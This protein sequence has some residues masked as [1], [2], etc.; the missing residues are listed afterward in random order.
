MDGV[1]MICPNCETEVSQV[2]D[3]RPSGNTIRRR[4]KCSACS[5]RF[6]T[7]EYVIGDPDFSAMTEVEDILAKIQK[8][9]LVALLKT[10]DI[11]KGF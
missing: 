7:R 1:N 3:S 8:D 5:E 9:A 10:K 4:R 6:T 11:V 2:I